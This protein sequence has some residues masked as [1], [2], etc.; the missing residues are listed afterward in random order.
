MLITIGYTILGKLLNT[1]VPQR[2]MNSPYLK[3]ISHE[4]LRIGTST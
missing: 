2:R 1:S 4:A 3:R